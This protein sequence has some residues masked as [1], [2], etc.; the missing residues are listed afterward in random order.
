[1]LLKFR[2]IRR[3]RVPSGAAPGLIQSF[4]FFFAASS[5]LAK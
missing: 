5:F 1:M 2:L 3:R 4:P